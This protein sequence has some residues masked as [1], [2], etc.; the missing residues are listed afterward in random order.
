M[1]TTY[2]IWDEINGQACDV[3]VGRTAITRRTYGLFRKTAVTN[4]PV[5]HITHV[6]H[7]PKRLS[8]DALTIVTASGGT[9][10][11][12]C[13]RAAE[14]AAEIEA[15]MNGDMGQTAQPQLQPPSNWSPGW[16]PDASGYPRWWNGSA[17]GQ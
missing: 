15:A 4:I 14:L 17:W 10:E 8:R 3:T 1:T 9:Y 12:K 6:H 11:W 5:N 13:D 16:Y 7:A 2:N